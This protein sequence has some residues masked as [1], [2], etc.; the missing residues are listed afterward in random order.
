MLALK[1]IANQRYLIQAYFND[2][3]I[4]INMSTDFWVNC[5]SNFSNE[6]FIEFSYFTPKSLTGRAYVG[7]VPA[8]IPHGNQT[9]NAE[10]KY[11]C[12][13]IYGKDNRKLIAYE[14]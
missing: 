4:K 12:R 10:K 1:T 8:E 13:E 11:A 3:N 2:R 14:S 5:N 6:D 7:L 9:L